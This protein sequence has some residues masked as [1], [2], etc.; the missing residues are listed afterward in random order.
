MLITLI[1][2]SSSLYGHSSNCIYFAHPLQVL[3]VIRKR[4]MVNGVT[5][6]ADLPILSVKTAVYRK[7]TD[8]ST[9]DIFFDAEADAFTPKL[10]HMSS[11]PAAQLALRSAL[12]C[13][14]PPWVPDPPLEF[15][16][17]GTQFVPVPENTGAQLAVLYSC[18]CVWGEGLSRSR[19]S[20]RGMRNFR[21]VFLSPDAWC[22]VCGG[23]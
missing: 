10:D 21:L 13:L 18:V 17:P 2:N 4:S 16:P 23:C 1:S 7:E 3:G 14:R 20:P 8:N 19:R 5:L 22:H 15:A 11:S 6:A 12:S 9:I